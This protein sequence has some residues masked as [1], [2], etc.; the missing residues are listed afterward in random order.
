[1]AQ[2]DYASAVAAVF[3]N[4]PTPEDFREQVE[5]FFVQLPATQEAIVDALRKQG[6][7][8]REPP[9][10]PP[11]GRGKVIPASAQLLEA[12]EIHREDIPADA[13]AWLGFHLPLDKRL[14]HMDHHGGSAGRRPLRPSIRDLPFV[15]S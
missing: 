13:V 4:P 15:A 11:S 7:V 14:W 9:P 1:M 6:A 12:M 10:V 5:S 8:V 3:R 2:G